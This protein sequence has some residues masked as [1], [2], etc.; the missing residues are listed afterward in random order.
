MHP[1]EVLWQLFKN[2]PTWDGDI[3]SKQSR[4]WL[5]EN[6]FAARTNGYT[7][8]T[9]DGVVAAIA[10]GCDKRKEAERAR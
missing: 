6:D 10:I 2:G 8:L 4:D 1:N 7:F 9:H 5:I 3:V